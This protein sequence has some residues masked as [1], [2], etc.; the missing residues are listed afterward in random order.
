MLSGQEPFHQ[1]LDVSYSRSSLDLLESLVNLLR[2][3]HLLLHLLSHERVP[4]LLNVQVLPILNLRL[5]LA[6]IG[7]LLSDLLVLLDSL[8][9]FL[10]GLLFVLEA[11]GNLSE[12]S[13][14]FSV[15]FL[16]VD[17]EAIDCVFGLQ[18]LL[19]DLAVLEALHLEDTELVFDSFFIF[20]GLDLQR[21]EILLH[22]FDH[23]VV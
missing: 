13:V 23:M 19:L 20:T 15:L 14:G 10:D 6:V 17:H 4:Q 8:H 21:E 22:P 3:L 18:P 9:S 16:D 11:L 5:I 12:D 1:F 7:S 2:V